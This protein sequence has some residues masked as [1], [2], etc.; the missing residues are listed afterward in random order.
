MGHPT[1]IC[2]IFVDPYGYLVYQR[3]KQSIL[4]SY[5]NL[6]SLIK[7]D[8]AICYT[9]NEYYKRT[10]FLQKKKEAVSIYI[11]REYV[12]NKQLLLKTL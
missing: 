8:L 1:E 6:S 11:K 4:Y 7:R 5:Q 3:V 9:E 10:Q 2:L 12:V